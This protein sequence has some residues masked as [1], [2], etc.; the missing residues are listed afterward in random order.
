MCISECRSALLVI[1]LL[2]EATRC[3]AVVLLTRRIFLH[4]CFSETSLK[5]AI[6]HNHLFPIGCQHMIHS[7]LQ[8]RP[9]RFFF[10]FFC[11]FLISSSRRILCRDTGLCRGKDKKGRNRYH[12]RLCLLFILIDSKQTPS[13]FHLFFL[14]N[15]RMQLCTSYFIIW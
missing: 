15:N 2:E 12:D 5:E 7:H 13:L 9:N 14:F 6:M 3:N 4:H 10:L 8:T 11:F 1:F